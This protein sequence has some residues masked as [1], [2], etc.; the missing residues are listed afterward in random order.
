MAA[1]LGLIADA[2]E[3]DPNELTP[4]RGGDRAT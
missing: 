1:D 2:A 4:H 3:A